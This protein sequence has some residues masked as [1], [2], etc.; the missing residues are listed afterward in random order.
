MIWLLFIVVFTPSILVMSAAG[1][2]SGRRCHSKGGKCDAPVPVARLGRL[3]SIRV[4]K[5]F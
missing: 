2:H 3:R 5:R 1:H 4:D